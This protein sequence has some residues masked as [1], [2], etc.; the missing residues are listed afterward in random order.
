MVEMLTKDYSLT[1]KLRIPAVSLTNKR[2]NIQVYIQYTCLYTIYEH[3][4]YIQVCIY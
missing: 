2:Y 4:I 3:N 1:N